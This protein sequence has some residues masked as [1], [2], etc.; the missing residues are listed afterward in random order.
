MERMTTR[1]RRWAPPE[2]NRD[3]DQSRSG[4]TLV[5]LLVVIAIIAI[6]ITLIM[7]ALSDARQSSRALVCAVRLRQLGLS[8]LQYSMD[9]NGELPARQ[10]RFVQPKG[11]WMETIS[12]YCPWDI[13][14]VSSQAYST[15]FCPVAIE[16]RMGWNEPDYGTNPYLFVSRAP[17]GPAG[18]KPLFPTWKIS[19]PTEVAMLVDSC[20]GDPYDGTW[21]FNVTPFLV[22][23]PRPEGNGINSLGARHRFRGSFL[24]GS[25]GAVFADGHASQVAYGDP[26]WLDR[27]NREMLFLP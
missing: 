24:T 17:D 21:L 5:E 20:K 8:I 25:F 18:G 10:E 7:P 12:S 14:P 11:L 1:L 15:Y 22:E 13:T 27:E 6:L 3:R 9:H 26:R 2:R 23:G 19:R 4:F 16:N